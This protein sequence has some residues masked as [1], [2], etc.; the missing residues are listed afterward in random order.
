M[1]NVTRPHGLHSNA[2]RR[3]HTMRP[4]REF[5]GGRCH[6]RSAEVWVPRVE[7]SAQAGTYP[8]FFLPWRDSGSGRR[9]GVQVSNWNLDA[10]GDGLR[11]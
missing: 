3:L 1:A 8:R 11:L 9:S 7:H 6:G 10:S 2:R 5:G 4:S